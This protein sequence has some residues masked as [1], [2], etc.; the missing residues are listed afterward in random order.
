[1]ENNL[2][3]RPSWSKARALYN[4]FLSNSSSGNKSSNIKKIKLEIVVHSFELLPQGYWVQLDN[5][6]CNGEKILGFFNFS[7]R[8]LQYDDN[9]AI[10]KYSQRKKLLIEVQLINLRDNIW[11]ASHII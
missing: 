9:L 1:M 4:Q 11:F 8:N 10:F 7:F 5:Y 6:W 2:D 3:E